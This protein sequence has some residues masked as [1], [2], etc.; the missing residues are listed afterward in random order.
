MRLGWGIGHVGLRLPEWRRAGAVVLTLEVEHDRYRR[1]PFPGGGWSFRRRTY[2]GL[3]SAAWHKFVEIMLAVFRLAIPV[4]LLLVLLAATYLYSDV[5]LPVDHIPRVARNSGLQVSDLVLPLAWFCIHLTNR[6]Y[7][8]GYAFAQ[9]LVAVVIGAG[10]LLL[11]RDYIDQWLSSM[12]SL[13]I[14]AVIAFLGAFLLANAAGIVIFDGARGPKWWT[15]P[16]GCLPSRSRWR[17]AYFIIP[18]HSL[19]RIRPGRGPPWCILRYFPPKRFC[20]CCPITCCGRRCRPCP[21]STAISFAGDAYGRALPEPVLEH[22][23]RYDPVVIIFCHRIVPGTSNCPGK[24]R[25]GSIVSVCCRMAPLTWPVAYNVTERAQIPPSTRP[26]MK[27]SS[28]VDVSDYHPRFA[29]QD[30]GAMNVAPDMPVDAG[31]AGEAIALREWPLAP[32]ARCPF[33]LVR[34]MDGGAVQSPSRANCSSRLTLA[35]HCNERVRA[36]LRPY[37]DVG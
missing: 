23:R 13:T 14:R 2:S 16:L 34:F 11:N 9:L 36:V 19:A 5:L 20:C 12:P 35:P 21:A 31:F 33:R 17:S 29:N 22:A 24:R 26:N 37:F 15:A 8:A 6:C 32:H 25:P 10:L 3:V 4:T 18:P 28:A 1:R 30:R 27:A 7:G